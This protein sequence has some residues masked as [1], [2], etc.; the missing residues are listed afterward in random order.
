MGTDFKTQNFEVGMEDS[1]FCGFQTDTSNTKQP[2]NKVVLMKLVIDNV[3]NNN[4]VFALVGWL[5][6]YFRTVGDYGSYY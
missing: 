6:T 5:V 4:I 2:L 3:M 1:Q